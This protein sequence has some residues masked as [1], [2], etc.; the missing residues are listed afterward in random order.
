[1]N[2]RFG[3]GLGQF[4]GGMFGNSGAPYD[5]AMNQYRQWMGKGEGALNP[6]M[7]AGQRGM[8]NFEDWL[9]GMKDPSGFINK[10]MGQYQESPWA[11]NLQQQSMR[12]GTNA[13]S[14]GGLPNGMGGAGAGS[15]PFSQQM[16]QNASNISGQDMG[17]WLQNV[18]GINS[19][20]GSGQAGLMG[21]GFNAA[22]SLAGMYNQMGGRMGEAAYGR[23]AGQDQDFWN[24]IGG[25]LGIFGS[26]FGG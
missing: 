20:Y 11:H 5:D 15:T 9:G 14:M 22:N 3:S 8:G 23:R 6:Y 21:Q 16:Q 18:L 10:M 26:M 7:Q 13:A 25:G 2:S 24:M 19:Q 17:N 1:M 4:L 12:A